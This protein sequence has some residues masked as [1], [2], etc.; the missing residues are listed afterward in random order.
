MAD[1]DIDLKP[2][3]EDPRYWEMKKQ[4]GITS[5][6]RHSSEKDSIPVAR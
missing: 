1:A 3:R 5:E 2:L 4:L 6:N